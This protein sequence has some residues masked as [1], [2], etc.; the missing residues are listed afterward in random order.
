MDLFI[1]IH[2][3]VPSVQDGLEAGKAGMTM[4]PPAETAHICSIMFQMQG[5]TAGEA[6]ELLVHL[7]RWEQ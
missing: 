6:N 3:S 4:P 5:L 2:G 1:S 7:P